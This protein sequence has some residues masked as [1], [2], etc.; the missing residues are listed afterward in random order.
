MSSGQWRVATIPRAQGRFEQLHLPVMC[1]VS[2]EG[3]TAYTGAESFF[4]NFSRVSEG[5]I[6]S[7]SLYRSVGTIV[8]VAAIN[9]L[10]RQSHVSP[11]LQA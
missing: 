11:G 5:S 3:V 1:A 2:A 9:T 10:G 4:L 7:H 8:S 6:C